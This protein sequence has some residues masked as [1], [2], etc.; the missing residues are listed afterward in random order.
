MYGVHIKYIYFFFFFNY[1][2]MYIIS[3]V[4][5]KIDTFYSTVYLYQSGTYY[6]RLLGKEKKQ[7]CIYYMKKD[8][9]KEKRKN[10]YMR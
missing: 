2:K 10:I 3:K 5:L 6:F 1:L 4:I 9:K 7:D 8:L